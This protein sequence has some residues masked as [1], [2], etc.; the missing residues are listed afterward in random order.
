MDAA[1]EALRLV[2]NAINLDKVLTRIAR[3]TPGSMLAGVRTH[4]QT[5]QMSDTSFGATNR[6]AKCN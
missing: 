1:N 6:S 3:L 5:T 2:G 4:Q